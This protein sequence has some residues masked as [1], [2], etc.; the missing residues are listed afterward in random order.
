MHQNEY[1]QAYVWSSGSLIS[2][3]YFHPQTSSFHLNMHAEVWIVLMLV[4]EM[5]IEMY[6]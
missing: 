3:W 6:L 2:Q 5:E 4:I 1:K